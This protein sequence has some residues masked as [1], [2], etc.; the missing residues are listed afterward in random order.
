VQQD[1][2]VA[3]TGVFL[4]EAALAL[5]PYAKRLDV[6]LIVESG[7]TRIGEMVHRHYQRYRNVFQ[8]QLNSHFIA[9]EVCD[10]AHSLLVKGSG[11]PVSAVIMSEQAAW[12]K[13]LN[14]AYQQCLPKAGVKV[15]QQISY[16]ADTSDFGPIYNK[17]ERLKPT[18]IVTGMAHTGLRPV[19][20][21]HQDRVPALMMGFNMQAGSGDFWARSNHAAQGLIVVTNGAGGAATTAKTP[22][23]YRAY[24]E[25]FKESPML[26]AYTS[27]D[28]VQALAEAIRSSGSTRTGALVDQLEKLDMVGVT[29][30]IRF[31]GRDARYTHALRYGKGL[32]TGVAFQWQAG[33]QTVIWP[34]GVAQGSLVYPDFVSH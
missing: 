31:Y 21:W 7:T 34:R 6:P 32:V 19:L 23:F 4:S 5:A 2:V 8:L 28:A 11:Q 14:R 9:Q 22:G 30:R 13:P 18:V 16:A 33:R 26:S 10:A 12:T 3:V 20:Q 27:Y 29:G 24:R 25:R 17:I 1:H 15:L